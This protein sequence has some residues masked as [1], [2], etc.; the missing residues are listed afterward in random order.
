MGAFGEAANIMEKERETDSKKN[1]KIKIITRS[2]KLDLYKVLSVTEK[3][4]GQTSSA[5]CKTKKE[6]SS[7]YITG[8]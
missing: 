1:L 3:K 6:Y 4:K 8:L 5:M 2:I 7:Y